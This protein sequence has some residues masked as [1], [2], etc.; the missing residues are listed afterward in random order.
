MNPNSEQMKSAVRW[1]LTSIGTVT[2]LYGTVSESLVVTIAGVATLLLPLIWGWLTHTQTN[3]VAVVTNIAK[4]PTSPVKGIVTTNNPAGIE[5]ALS[6]PG[7]Q[8]AA[9]GTNE[10]ERMA[11]GFG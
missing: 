3:A 2:G 10:A 6:I 9:A 11:S 5:L 1:L 4:D 8:I 7:S